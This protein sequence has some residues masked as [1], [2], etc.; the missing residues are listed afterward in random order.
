MKILYVDDNEQVLQQAENKL[1]SLGHRVS[2]ASSYEKAYDILRDPENKIQLVIADHMLA[3]SGGFNLILGLQQSFPNVKVVVLSGEMSRSEANQLEQA[4]I[5]Y[6]QKPVLLEKVV[7][8][9]RIPPPVNTPKATVAA[10]Q[11][12][13]LLGQDTSAKP[14]FFSRMFGGKKAS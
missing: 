10:A 11:G 2:I 12:E 14:G 9:I 7:K 13:G 1:A 6:F 5:P 3:G 8:G 4:D